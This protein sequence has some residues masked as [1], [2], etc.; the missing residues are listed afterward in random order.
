VLGVRFPDGIRQNSSEES[1]KVLKLS[2]L[3]GS[4]IFMATSQT[5]R[6]TRLEFLDI[7]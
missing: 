3:N 2:F 5:R 1:F 7:D 6:V 4:T